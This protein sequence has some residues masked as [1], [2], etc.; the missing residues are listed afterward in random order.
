[1]VAGRHWRAQFE[2]WAHATL[3]RQAGVSEEVIEAVRTGTPPS[4]GTAEER[5]IYD[6]VTEYFATNRVSDAT[7]ASAKKLFGEKGVVDIIGIAGYY[8][9]V[10]MTLNVFQVAVPEGEA[11]PFENPD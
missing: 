11:R 1:M 3:A 9:L 7:Y 5:A 2:Y 4:L 6:F 8:G 10:S